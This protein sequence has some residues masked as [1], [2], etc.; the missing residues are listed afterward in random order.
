[1]YE[2]PEGGS[3]PTGAVWLAVTDAT[4]RRVLEYR[5][6]N[7]VAGEPRIFSEAMPPVIGPAALENPTDVAY[8]TTAG[9]ADVQLYAVDGHNRVV[10]LR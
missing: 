8:T 4:Q 1:M 5:P 7:G 3:Q 6:Q 2:L 9:G 10:R